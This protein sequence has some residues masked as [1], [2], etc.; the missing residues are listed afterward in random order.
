MWNLA[1][2]VTLIGCGKSSKGDW[3]RS[4]TQYCHELESLR[5][6]VA[7]RLDS[8]LATTKN[9]ALDSP[10]VDPQSR[11]WQCT[12]LYADLNEVHGMLDGF[13]LAARAVTDGGK[14]VTVADYGSQPLLAGRVEYKAACRE[15]KIEAAAKLLAD[16]K[17]QTLASL[18]K[19]TMSCNAK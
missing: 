15:G 9:T 12:E 6:T 10:N 17:T 18:D 3:D 1:L 8:T 4:W 5:T 14:D 11:T 19:A 16:I 13:T 7:T 2:V